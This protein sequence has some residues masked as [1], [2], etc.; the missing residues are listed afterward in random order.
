MEGITDFYR[1]LYTKE[2]LVEDSDVD[3]FNL[4]AKISPLQKTKLD[5]EIS[6]EEMRKALLSCKETAPGPDGI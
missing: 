4:C 1:N 2:I 5:D 3:F 6:L